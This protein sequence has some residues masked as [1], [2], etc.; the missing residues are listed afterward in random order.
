MERIAYIIYNTISLSKRAFSNN[1]SIH[2]WYTLELCTPG[3][4]C[5]SCQQFR[6]DLAAIEVQP[7]TPEV[8]CRSEQMTSFLLDSSFQIWHSGTR[9]D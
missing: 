5:L 3:Y 6:S 8:A 7:A 2:S 9:V 1:R 4:P